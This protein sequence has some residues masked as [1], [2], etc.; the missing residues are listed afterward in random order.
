MDDIMTN[1]S[2]LFLGNGIVIVIGCLLVG[3]ILKGTFKKLPNKYIPVLNSIIAIVLGFIIPDTFSD[4]SI[5]AKVILLVF[6]GFS[7]VG[8]YEAICIIIKDRFSVDL[9]KIY[10]NLINPNKSSSSSQKQED[11]PNSDDNSDDEG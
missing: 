4:Q 6:I 10:N 1:V 8:L 3:S 9:K 7:S 5:L 11:L 2:D